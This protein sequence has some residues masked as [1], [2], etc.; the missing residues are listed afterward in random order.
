MNQNQIFSNEIFNEIFHFLYDMN[1]SLF[2]SILVSRRWAIIGIP[3]LW[4]L[5]FMKYKE[6]VNEEKREIM[7]ED[8]I[9]QI[10]K[11]STLFEYFKYVKMIDTCL[12]EK[13]QIKTR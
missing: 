10:K 11:K 2:N 12:T 13:F 9:I 7:I 6:I 3:I 8:L 1:E 5:P 4:Q